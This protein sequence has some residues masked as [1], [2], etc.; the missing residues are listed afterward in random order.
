MQRRDVIKS[1]IAIRQR[2]IPYAVIEREVAL[3]LNSGKI[4]TIPGVRRCGKS[5]MM[6]IAVNRLV[7]QGVEPK[8]ILWLGFDDERLKDMSASELNGVIEAYMEMYPDVEF[9]SAYL[10][11]DELQLIKGWEYFV[12]RLYKNYCK[13]IFVCG[14]NATMLSSQLVSALRGYPLQQEVWPLSFGEYCKFRGID[15]Q[16]FLE[17]DKA[18]VRAAFDDYAHD[19]SFP[20]IVLTRQ[21][22]HQLRLLQGYFD[23]MLLRDLV[24]HYQI[25][26]VAMVRYF[27]KRI[28]AN[29][30]KP[31]SINAIYRDIRSQGLP[32]TKNDLYLWA[33]YVC[34]IF[35]FVRIPRYERSLKRE[36]SAPCKYY[37]IDNGLRRAV[38]MP[39]SSDEGKCLENLVFMHLHSHRQPSDK[40]CYYQ[41]KRE[42]DFVVQ[43]GDRVVQLVQATWDTSDMETRHREVA[44]LLEAAAATG[45]DN[46]FI[47]T[48]GE[49]CEC[50]VEGRTIHVMPAWKWLLNK[51]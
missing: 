4:I 24:E 51:E 6:E 3:P 7:R 31:T 49:E 42:C 44:G 2:E 46:L 28:M 8:R 10:F 22:S 21:P 40:I 26:N 9:A 1:L 16:S 23:T 13:N 50:T 35:L 45:C 36:Q 30:T 43:R 19:S 14:S 41:G 32:V 37:C 12:L 34:D 39:Q 5:T 29:L 47:V 20:E 27:V 11:F 18:R 48:H 33:N 38:L 15:T 17:H 25:R